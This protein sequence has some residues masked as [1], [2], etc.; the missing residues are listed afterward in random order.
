MRQK[1]LR[2]ASG[3]TRADKAPCHS[4]RSAMIGVF[5]ILASPYALVVQAKHSAG[6]EWLETGVGNCSLVAIRVS[7]EPSQP[8]MVSQ[9]I[10]I[11]RRT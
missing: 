9:Y 1:S 5:L 11:V 3:N 7:R 6:V 2:Y 10:H 8:E 4:N